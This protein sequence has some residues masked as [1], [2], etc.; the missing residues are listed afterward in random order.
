MTTLQNNLD[1]IEDLYRECFYEVR[2][3]STIHEFD[4]GNFARE[5]NIQCVLDSEAGRTDRNA[6]QII[7][8]CS[9]DG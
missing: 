1:V 6:P 2:V 5:Y 9:V 8:G 3:F 7:F 4:A